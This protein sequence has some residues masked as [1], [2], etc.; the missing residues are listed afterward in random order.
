M[1]GPSKG[2]LSILYIDRFSLDHIRLTV[3]ATAIFSKHPVTAIPTE[4]CI[5]IRPALFCAIPIQCLVWSNNSNP[6]DDS[7]WKAQ[8][9]PSLRESLNLLPSFLVVI[10]P[11]LD[12]IPVLRY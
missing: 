8:P 4:H 11:A 5:E 9:I 3:S 10:P 2:N 1:L 7:T 12:H 6:I